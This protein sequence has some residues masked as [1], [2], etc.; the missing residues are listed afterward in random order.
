MEHILFLK[1]F[2]KSQ[3]L[4]MNIYIHITYV[5][6]DYVIIY[7]GDLMPLV[8]GDKIFH[9]YPD[10]FN[11]YMIVGKRGIG[12]TAYALKCLHQ[13]F[14]DMGYS[15]NKAWKLALDCL[16]FSI[17]T[18]IKY[19]EDALDKREIKVC[20]IW[21]DLRVFAGGSQ[22]HLQMKMVS[23][24][25]GMLDTIRTAICSLIMTCPSQKG[26]LSIF[27]SYDDYLVKIHHNERG[28]WYRNAQGYL[29][30]TLPSGIRRIYRKYNDSFSCY[31][32]KWV[33]DQYMESRHKAMQIQLKE[34][35]EVV[36][37][38]N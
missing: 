11:S 10:S 4:K 1:F 15:D 25:G 8:L 20:L 5:R 33:Y 19:L 9:T 21:D 22:Y 6:K 32:P 26:L 3:K 13:C 16:H 23:K 2:V 12:K 7:H 37:E 17:P 38:E 28:G 30:S 27:Q 35:K 29:W 14:I 36:E 24:L 18:V 31:L 34:I